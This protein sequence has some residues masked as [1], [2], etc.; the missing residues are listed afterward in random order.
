[1]E[2]KGDAGPG[3]GVGRNGDADLL[4]VAFGDGTVNH[5]AKV[6]NP[7]INAEDTDLDIESSLGSI[8]YIP[9]D[10]T[11]DSDID[12]FGY[13]EHIVDDSNFANFDI[14]TTARTAVELFCRKS[15]ERRCGQGKGGRSK[16]KN[17]KEFHNLVAE[18]K[19]ESRYN[20]LL[21]V[22]VVV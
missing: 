13:V 7:L 10:I 14:T 18:E 8:D 22:K 1:M 9:Q 21:K 20:Q 19:R 17:R 16:N 6:E 5:F 2:A 12:I 15:P 3:L 4:V 11:V